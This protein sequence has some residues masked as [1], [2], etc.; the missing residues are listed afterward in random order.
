MREE[1]GLRKGSHGRHLGDVKLHQ[2]S[3]EE[4]GGGGGGEAERAKSSGKKA[5]ADD[6]FYNT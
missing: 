6:I 5:R 3:R 2:H 4:K 1:R